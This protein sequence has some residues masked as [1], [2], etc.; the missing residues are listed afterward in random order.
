MP[1]PDGDIAD[2]CVVV[3]KDGD[4]VS[5]ALVDDLD[6]SGVSREQIETLDPSR[7]HARITFDGAE[8]EPLGE[9]GQGWALK[10]RVFDRAAVLFA[11]EQLGGADACLQMAIGYAKG[12]YALRPADRLLPGDQA[13]A[14]RHLHQER[15]RPGELLLRRL[16]AVDAMRPSCRSR[17]PRPALPGRRPST[18]RLEGE[19]PDTW[20]HRLHLGVRL[21]PLLPP[22]QAPGAQHRQ[23]ESV[24]GPAHL[25]TGTAG[26]RLMDFNDT[27]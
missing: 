26:G 7:S 9:A 17:R 1:V 24:E 5:L 25:R 22:L 23:R 6:G 15:T 14:R 11:M 19:H 10:D 20:R 13:Q 3:A 2:F 27:P 18:A 12:R 21:P 16:G 4:G 8:A